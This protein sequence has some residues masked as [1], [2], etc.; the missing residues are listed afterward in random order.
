MMYYHGTNIL[1]DA[2]NL[3]KC[4]NRTD[5]GKGF[6]LADKVE[7]AQNWA[8]RRT[9]LLNGT[10][11]IIKYEINDSLFSLP[12]MRF[13]HTPSLEWLHFISKNRKNADKNT[14]TQEPRHDYNWVSGP[15]ANDKIA[16]VVDE[17]LNGEIT[18]S[19]AIKKARAL[20]Y[21]FQLSLHTKQAVMFSNDNEVFY[22]QLINNRWTN[23]WKKR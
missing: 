21:T 9:Q 22:K 14:N 5:F 7:T 2:I 15:I 4:R 20:P 1:I 12:G 17:F 19:E 18:D 3:N 8:I 16:D 10:P 13:K 11:T 23:D 6:Y